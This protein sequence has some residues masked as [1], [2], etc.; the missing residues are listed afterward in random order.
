MIDIP[1]LINA[2]FEF[3]AGG[4]LWLSCRRV[5]IDKAVSGVSTIT[6]VFFTSWGFWNLYYYPSLNQYVSG[7]FAV[8]ATS[9]NLYRAYLLWKYRSVT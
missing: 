8:F 9:V 4:A 7:V 5:R 2:A 6:V 1:D 3:L